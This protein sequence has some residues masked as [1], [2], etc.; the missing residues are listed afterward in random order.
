[1]LRPQH[2][3]AVN[4][5]LQGYSKKDAM[6]AA[7]YEESYG[8]KKPMAVFDRD[9]VKAEI[10]KRQDAYAKRADVTAEWIIERLKYIAD[11]N[12]GDIIEI[13]DDGTAKYNLKLLTP[14]MAV[15]L[16]E[17]S[18][19]TYTEGRGP[20]ARKVK[21]MKIKQLD[22]LR[23]LEML[24]RHVGLFND[25]LHISGELSLR[26]R[27]NAGRRRSAEASEGKEE[28]GEAHS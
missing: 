22:K 20:G 23:A 21:R 27:L 9:D 3:I 1:M 7:G 11:A 15:A 2:Q 8:A 26:D 19:D 16:G 13:Q 12:I 6:V 10:K 18:I 4:K 5:Y 24:S 28:D 25:T 17:M 14:E